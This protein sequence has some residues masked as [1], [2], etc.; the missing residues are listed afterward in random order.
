MQHKEVGINLLGRNFWLSDT[1]CFPY[2]TIGGKFFMENVL[3][4][5]PLTTFHLERDVSAVRSSQK[6]V[7][8]VDTESC[9][10]ASWNNYRP[11]WRHKII[12]GL[13]RARVPAIRLTSNFVESEQGWVYGLYK[14]HEIEPGVL[15]GTS[16]LWMH[17][18]STVTDLQTATR[19]YWA[20]TVVCSDLEK[21]K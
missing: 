15:S 13:Q 16:G 10:R 8:A 21:D 1:F 4:I 19:C 5:V 7:L 6:S 11:W 12:L 20:Q 2:Y 17:W 14:Q 18:D 3:N 9:T